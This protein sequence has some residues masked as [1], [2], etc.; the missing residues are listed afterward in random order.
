MA[1]MASI[2]YKNFDMMAIMA[3]RP[4]EAVATKPPKMA[5]MASMGTKGSN[6]AFMPSENC[7]GTFSRVNVSV[8]VGPRLT[9]TPWPPYTNTTTRKH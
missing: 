8:F 2:L 4:I 6:K 1:I 9:N 7:V 5:I 3:S